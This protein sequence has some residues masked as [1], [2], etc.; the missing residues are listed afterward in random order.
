MRGWKTALLLD[1]LKDLETRFG[2]KIGNIRGLGLYQ[3]FTVWGPGNKGRLIEMA[4][5]EENYLLLGAGVYSVRLRPPLDVGADD[6]RALIETL[7]RLL[8]RL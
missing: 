2:D 1:G 4:L 6:I 8:E 3:G 5:Q 7:G